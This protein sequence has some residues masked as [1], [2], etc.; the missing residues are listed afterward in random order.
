MLTGLLLLMCSNSYS[1]ALA[2]ENFD[3]YKV[4]F[5]LNFVKY[6][7]NSS[8]DDTICIINNPEIY[9][10]MKS[11]PNVKSLDSVSADMKSC[12]LIYISKKDSDKIP[13]LISAISGKQIITVSDATG[14][15]NKGGIIELFEDA[16][17][18]RFALNMKKAT[19]LKLKVNSKLVEIADKTI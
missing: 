15:A 16:G 9:D 10:I 18:L 3:R 11:K 13:E 2:A 5:I 17:K 14:F 7:E 6:I 12:A 4:A 8:G 19:S 1:F